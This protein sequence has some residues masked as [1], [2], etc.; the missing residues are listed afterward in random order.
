[1][2]SSALDLDSF[3][4]LRLDQLSLASDDILREAIE[5]V[6]GLLS[7]DSSGESASLHGYLQRQ[8]SKM[9]EELS[10]RLQSAPVQAA[11]HVV[12]SQQSREATAANGY[13]RGNRQPL[14]RPLHSRSAGAM[15]TGAWYR[16]GSAPSLGSAQSQPQAQAQ[17]VIPFVVEATERKKR[18]L[19]K[20]TPVVSREEKIDAERAAR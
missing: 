20:K 6:L 9:R 12:S 2:S 17:E 11:A 1:M 3:P 5:G 18:V 10:Q 8:L 16:S 13:I 14:D 15:K 4:L 7:S 19:P